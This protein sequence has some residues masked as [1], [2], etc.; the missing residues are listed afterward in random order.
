MTGW[1]EQQIAAT[2]AGGEITLEAGMV[3]DWPSARVD[4][5]LTIK[6][7][8]QVTLATATPPIVRGNIT[9][10]ASGLRLEGF[11]WQGT[12]ATVPAFT[13]K[14]T[15]VLRDLRFFGL[16]L[17]G[18]QI[19]ATAAG[20]D[21][22]EN[23]NGWLVENVMVVGAA[24]DGLSVFGADA[25]AGRSIGFNAMNCGR[26]GLYD[27]SFLGNTHIGAHVA[28]SGGASY[29]TD[30]ANANNLFLGCYAEGGQPA[31]SFVRPTMVVGGAMAG[32][33][34]LGAL[35]VNKDGGVRSKGFEFVDSTVEGQVGNGWVSRWKSVGDSDF[36]GWHRVGNYWTL[37]YAGNANNVTMRIGAPSA[38]NPFAASFPKVGI[39]GWGDVWVTSG[40][41]APTTGTWTRATRVINKTPV[42]GGVEGW[43]CVASGTP[44]TWKAFGSIAT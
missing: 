13:M 23:A 8:G 24:Q 12:D 17:D 4:K 11:W 42:A 15:A 3:Y 35:T 1:L 31:P 44:G 22:N 14:R 36:S 9:G 28:E 43:V 25:N 26:H 20:S 38:P 18:V 6:G 39:G 10:W 29:K 7:P 2:P 16:M 33:D 21:P 37:D 40:T 41:A 19:N 34:Y 30:N 32:L 27:S 5:V